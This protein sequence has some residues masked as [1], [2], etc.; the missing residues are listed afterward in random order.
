MYKEKQTGGRGLENSRCASLFFSIFDIW[1]KTMAKPFKLK[2]FR[3]YTIAIIIAYAPAP[4]MWPSPGRGPDSKSAPKQWKPDVHVKRAT[5]LSA[6]GGHWRRKPIVEIAAIKKRVDGLS[7]TQ[8]GRAAAQNFEHRAGIEPMSH[9]PWPLSHRFVSM[10]ELTI[11]TVY[12]SSY[13]ANLNWF[14]T[15]RIFIVGLL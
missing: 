12:E 9:E 15:L 3:G 6:R 4:H 5:T 7:A 1:R 10:I 14:F 13:L 11:K 8:N 2:L